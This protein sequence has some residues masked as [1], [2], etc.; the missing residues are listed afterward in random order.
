[1]ERITSLWAIAPSLPDAYVLLAKAH[2]ELG[3]AASAERVILSAPSSAGDPD[4]P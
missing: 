4:P 3:E 1:M 2:L